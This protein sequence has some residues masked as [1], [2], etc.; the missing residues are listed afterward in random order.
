MEEK[1]ENEA[2]KRGE[3]RIQLRTERRNP[4]FGEFVQL[5]EELV[6]RIQ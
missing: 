5:G 2:R 3:K 6:Q 4:L 1:K